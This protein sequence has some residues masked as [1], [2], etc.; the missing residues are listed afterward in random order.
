MRLVTAMREDLDAGTGRTA[1]SWPGFQKYLSKT[2]IPKFPDLTTNLLQILI[3]T[4][5]ISLLCQKRLFILQLCPEDGLFGKY[6]VY[7][8][9][10]VKIEN[11]SYKFLP[12]QNGGFQETTS[13]KD[14]QD[15]SWLDL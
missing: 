9:Q 14:R 12:V 1:G 13:P 8:P 11:S 10:K 6:F 15:G 7:Y 5:F 2:A 3:P 4:T